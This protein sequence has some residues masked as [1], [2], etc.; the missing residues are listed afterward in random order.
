MVSLFQAPI[1]SEMADLY[2][3]NIIVIGCDGVHSRTRQ[4]LLDEADFASYATYTHKA[5]YRAVVP[6]A[7]A[8]DAFGHDKAN[9][10]C[11]HMGPDGV[12]IS[13]PVSV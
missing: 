13:Y 3:G 5:A 6:I 2:C 4:L 8:I 7:D 11:M 10:Q 12:V 9:N 1:Y